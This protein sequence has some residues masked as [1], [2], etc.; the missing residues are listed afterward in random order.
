M[1]R[2]AL[3]L[4]RYHGFEINLSLEASTL[5]FTNMF[6]TSVTCQNPEKYFNLKA[7]V[8]RKNW[9]FSAELIYSNWRA[10]DA[11]TTPLAP[12]QA[13]AWQ[14]SNT[15]LFFQPLPSD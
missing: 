2:Y 14:T 11:G 8:E 4:L 15:C 12:P 1:A 13:L 3:W 5:K 7:V 6:P 9:C 10:L